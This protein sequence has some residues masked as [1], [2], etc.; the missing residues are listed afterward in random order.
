MAENIKGP[1]VN[2]LQ[3]ITEQS[4]EEECYPFCNEIFVDCEATPPKIK[5]LLKKREEQLKSKDTT[6]KQQTV[7]R[8][9][10]K[11]K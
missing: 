6:S 10:R 1:L 2:E 3:R 8:R 7:P 9:R 11:G 5:E 4:L